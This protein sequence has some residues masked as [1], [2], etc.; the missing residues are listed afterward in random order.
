MINNAHCRSTNTLCVTQLEDHLTEMIHHKIVGLVFQHYK[1]MVTEDDNLSILIIKRIKMFLC[2]LRTF[3][4][5]L[6]L[7]TLC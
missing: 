3:F 5:L 6:T 2:K 7:D 4:K 1:S